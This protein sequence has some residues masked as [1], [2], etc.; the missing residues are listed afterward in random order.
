MCGIFAAFNIRGTYDEARAL[1]YKLSRRQ[2]HRGPDRSGLL[3]Y[4]ASP[5][6]FHILVHERLNIVDLS[7]HGKQPFVLLD[8]PNIQFLANGE[9]YNYESHRAVL[10]KKY[11]FQGHSDC[12][13]IGMLYK[14][15]KNYIII[16]L[17]WS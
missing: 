5:G 13:I 11:R 15:V 2:R 8:D 6:L 7:E 14:E 16:F 10:E 3:I 4:E 17:V 12:E 9:I 1:A